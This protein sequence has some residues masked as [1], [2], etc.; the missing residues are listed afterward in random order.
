[1]KRQE[2]ISLTLA[3]TSLGMLSATAGCS[4]KKEIQRP[5]RVGEM[6]DEDC[7]GLKPDDCKN[8]REQQDIGGHE[9][10]FKSAE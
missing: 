6:S 4:D 2:F 7:S 8:R 3:L 10:Q 9:L 5:G 1:M